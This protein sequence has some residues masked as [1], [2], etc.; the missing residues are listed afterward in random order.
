MGFDKLEVVRK[1]MAKAERAATPEEAESYTGMALRLCARHGIDAAL[2]DARRA[3][4][5]PAADHPGAQ[6]IPVHAPYSAAKARLLSWTAQALRCRVVLHQAR[7]G[8]VDAVTVFGFA[9]DRARVELLY[10]S[11]LLQ[12]CAELVRLRPVLRGE[13]VAAY[14]RSWLYGFAHRVHQR[15]VEAEQAAADAADPAERADA[16]TTTSVALVLADRDDRVARAFA[17]EFPALGR[18]R[19]PL[20]SGSGRAA[21]AAAGSRADLGGTGLAGAPRRAV[22]A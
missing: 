15:L 19:G 1:L 16:G 20:L 4:H 8:R 14:R 13:S 17:E 22:G 12:A 2:V 21:G 7:G 10:T 3:A 11:L 6:R 18:A 9:A 5:D